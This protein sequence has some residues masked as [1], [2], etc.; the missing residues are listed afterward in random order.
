MTSQKISVLRQ[1]APHR[2]GHHGLILFAIICHVVAYSQ[3]TQPVLRRE[4]PPY[5]H[6]RGWVPRAL[7]V[8]C[9][10][11][12]GVVRCS[13]LDSLSSPQDYGDGGA[14]PEIHVAQYP[15]N[16]GRKKGAVSSS[17]QPC[18]LCCT[19]SPLPLSLPPPSL[20]LLPPSPTFLPPSFLPSSTQGLSVIHSDR[21]PSTGCHREGEVRCHRK[22]WPEQR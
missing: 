15:M 21:S 9:G 10:D 11:P 1:T 12:C 17:P 19:T 22:D 18:P 5:G 3:L 4:P 6:R 8:S 20:S 7:E 16:M 2:N 13:R 14:F